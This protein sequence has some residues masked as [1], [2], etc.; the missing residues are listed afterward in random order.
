MA[1]AVG[2]TL[3]NAGKAAMMPA[4]FA[5]KG[6]QLA[7]KT[8]KG[9]INAGR[10]VKHGIDQF[11]EHKAEKGAILNDI[12]NDDEAK[13]E[14]NEM[15]GWQQRKTLKRAR[16]NMSDDERKKA[17][18]DS[19]INRTSYNSFYTNG[20]RMKAS[21]THGETS[22]QIRDR[23]ELETARRKGLGGRYL[24]NKHLYEQ[25]IANNKA[26]MQSDDYINA[27]TKTNKAKEAIDKFKSGEITKS[28]RDYQLKKYKLTKKESDS[29]LDKDINDKQIESSSENI[30]D[31]LDTRG[32]L[33]KF[34][35]G[36]IGKDHK[37]AKELR[38]E[39]FNSRMFGTQGSD[40]RES[41]EERIAQNATKDLRFRH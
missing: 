28:Q 12:M 33:R 7:G 18:A 5:V 17:H 30:K 20:F 38:Y 37:S 35:S 4:R 40:V 23:Q 29:L 21:Q 26:L 8:I 14:F 34:I 16:L 19:L 41:A 22:D 39:N 27:T 25:G 1:G 15:S 24:A 9:G 11:K 32:K 2:G 10:A 13:K 6:F 31:I 36:K 3:V